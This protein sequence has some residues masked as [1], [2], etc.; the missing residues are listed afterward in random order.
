MLTLTELCQRMTKLDEITIM[1][2]LEVNSEDLVQAFQDRIEA[3]Y[4]RLAEELI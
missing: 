3:D 4:D 1:E 2:V